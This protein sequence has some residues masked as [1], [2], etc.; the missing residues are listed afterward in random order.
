MLRLSKTILAGVGSAALLS[1]NPAFAQ[2]GLGQRLDAQEQKLSQDEQNCREVNLAEYAR[3]LQ[4]ASENKQRAE[5]AKKKGVP[6]D[7]TQVNADLGRAMQ[8]FARAQAAQARQ[9]MM[10]AQGALPQTTPTPAASPP[11]TPSTQGEQSS[12]PTQQF[13]EDVFPENG[14][15]ADWPA[16]SFFE[17]QVADVKAAAHRGDKYWAAREAENLD[18]W[19]TAIQKYLKQAEETGIGIRVEEFRTD[20]KLIDDMM[21]IQGMSY[22]LLTAFGERGGDIPPLVMDH[23]GK[24]EGS[25][26]PEFAKQEEK[27]ASPPTPT[28]EAANLSPFAKTVLAEHNEAR[29]AVGAPPLKWNPVL[30]QHAVARAQE[31][32]RIG[33]LVHAP[34]EGRGT[35]RENILSAPRGYSPGQM[36]NQWIS[37][38]RY[39]HPESFPMYVAG[40]GRNARITRR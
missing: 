27:P 35:E 23:W 15:P 26:E 7:E 33:Q 32:A 36:I 38:Q 5:K 31:I 2:S 17:K 37:E 10:R 9:C 34:R 12:I 19:R 20:L 11:T 25:K 1:A 13:G 14:Y 18:Y 4:E 39:F 30:E 21:K 16:P 40:T 28:E 8:L 3:L 24:R 22:F 6:V 29:A